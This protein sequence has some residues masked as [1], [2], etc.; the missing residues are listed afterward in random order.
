VLDPDVVRRADR[1]ALPAGVARELR[2]A[3][4]VA[5]ETRTNMDRA[6]FAR[7]ALVDGRVGA[8][9]APHGHL[10]AAM[11]LSIEDGRITKIDVV[12]DPNRLRRLDLAV[13]D[14]PGSTP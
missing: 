6:R 3:R 10:V 9:I 14:T 7:T 5:E 2:G 11:R 4:A 1:V 12:A 13:L 8:V